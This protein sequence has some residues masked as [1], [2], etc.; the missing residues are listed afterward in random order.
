MEINFDLI[1]DELKTYSNWVNWVIGIKDGKPTKIPINPKTGGKAQSNNPSTWGTFELAFKKWKESENGGIEGVGFMFSDGFTGVDLD[2][3]ID[4]NTGLINQKWAED[5]INTLN[6][7]SEKTP[8]GKGVHVLTKGPLPT[9]GRKKG[10]IEMYSSGRFFTVTGH[11][12]P[13][14]PTVIYNREKELREIHSK[15]IAT[16]A[17]SSKSNVP[18][19]SDLIQRAK[20]AKDGEKFRKLW[21]GDFSD[22]PSQSEADLALCLLLAFWTNRDTG[23]IDTLFRQS[24]LMREKWDERHFG[25]GRTYG[26]AT[27]QTAIERT[28]ET[29]QTKNT[30]PQTSESNSVFEVGINF[31]DWGNAKRLVT[32][33]GTTL[34]YCYTW[35]KWLLWD[36]KRWISDDAGE[37]NRKAKNTIGLIYKE[38]AEEKDNDRRKALASHALRCE[39]DSKLKAMIELAKSEP[40][41]PI[42][43]DDMDQDPW[44]FNVLNGTLDLRTGEL[45]SHHREDYITKISEVEYNP[46]ADC[47]FWMQHLQKI[48]NG[49]S[50]LILFLQRSFGYSLTGIIDERNLFIG[51]GTGANGKTTTHEVANKV[52]G[53]YAARTP[54]ETLLIKREGSIPHDLAILKGSRFVFCSESE[55]GKRLAES[56]IKDLTGGDTISARFLYSHLFTFKPTFKVWL[57]TNHKPIIRGTDNAIWDRIRLI[58]F[59][60]SIPE[61]ERIPQREMM[62]R[63]QEEISGILT[64]MVKGSLEWVKR[65]LGTP[66]EVKKAT[67]KYRDEMDILGDFIEERCVV[68]NTSEA[69]SKELYNRYEEWCRGNGEKP[70][71]QKSFA[72]RLE[73]RAF[74]KIRMGHSQARG[75]QG[76]GLNSNISPTSKDLNTQD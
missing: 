50:N 8:S 51:W 47:P 43:P 5:I 53:N 20:Q 17:P 40:G 30:L 25:D 56:L 26:Q 14:T 62:D 36:G 39:S 67:S 32:A 76:I 21:E 29:Y 74:V 41:I 44:L 66:E 22:Y 34:R 11:H 6:S 9:G 12:L 37:I 60:V 42:R 18:T 75:W 68:S 57:A 2:K 71:S 31:T 23:R 38:A 3:C 4:P 61:P 33:Y 59:T 70:I 52:M 35:A 69:T 64:W 28:N 45:K 65:G 54:A 49:N 58:P 48:M 13:E 24:K 27:I 15:Y 7:Y 19:D 1:P 16:P 72:H 73:E 10:D 55:E 46:E 63:F